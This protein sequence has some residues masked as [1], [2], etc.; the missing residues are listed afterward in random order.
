MLDGQPVGAIVLG[1]GSSQ[2]M[3]GRDKVFT[4]LCGRPALAWVLDALERAPSVDMVAVVLSPE[5][6]GRGQALLAAGSWRKPIGVCLG[7]ARRQDSVRQGLGALPP[8]YWVVVHDAG[9]PCLTPDLVERCLASARETG[10]TICAVPAKDTVK[11]VNEDLWV[12]ETLP[13]ERL[14]LVQTP[15]AFR[16]ALLEEAHRRIQ[17]TVT[18]DASMV[19]RLGVRVKV[20][21]GDYSNLKITTPEDIPMAEA[22]LRSRPALREAHQQ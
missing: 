15:Q 6:V 19:E 16:R 7:G 4:P 1:A 21:M 8:C 2:R 14:W 9:R 22:I 20:V 12:V 13:R 5:N 17:E 18:D 11:V 10:S 3:G